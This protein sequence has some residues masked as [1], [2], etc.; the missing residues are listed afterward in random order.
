MKTR[1]HIDRIFESPHYFGGEFTGGKRRLP[2]FTTSDK[3]GANWYAHERSDAGKIYQGEIKAEHPFEIGDEKSITTGLLPLLDKLGIKYR[4]VPSKTHMGWWLEVP[5]ISNHSPNEGSNPLDV[6]YIPAVR[7]ELIRQGYD[8]VTGW[9]NLETTDI[10]VTILIKDPEHFQVTHEL[11]KVPF[12][13]AV[14]PTALFA[15]TWGGRRN[16]KQSHR[17]TGAG[18]H[19]HPVPAE[20][21]RGI[22]RVVS[23]DVLFKGVESYI[24]F[25]FYGGDPKR[26]IAA[27]APYG[28]DS[29]SHGELE[30][31]ID[32]KQVTWSGEPQEPGLLDYV[33]CEGRAALMADVLELKGYGPR[34]FHRARDYDYIITFWDEL[35][36]VK[37]VLLPAVNLCVKA[38]HERGNGGYT[39]NTSKWFLVAADW[40]GPLDG[41]GDARADHE[42][43]AKMALQRQ[44][45]L[46]RPEVKRAMG[47][48]PQYTKA[49]PDLA[50]RQQSF[51]SEAVKAVIGAPELEEMRHPGDRL[52]FE[53]HCWESPES[54]DAQLWYRSHQK[55]TLLNLADCEGANMPSAKERREEACPLVY[56]VKFDDGFVGDAMEDE[57]MDS[58]KQFNRPNPPKMPLGDLGRS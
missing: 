41:A 6:V 16:G 34:K 48:K 52:W 15:R 47:I 23:P 45:H 57:L 55:V 5:E 11:D 27:M 1:Q 24:T 50:T 33:E 32:M 43:A 37:N 42:Q 9:D 4:Y 20:N 3:S 38:S 19:I 7:E 12:G 28:G 49:G 8:S 53:Y 39:A 18:C 22:K 26:G 30:G 58:R 25:G 56:R 14:A 10:P 31:L 51:T 40:A 35:E 17:A 2:I 36:T 29:I 46:A 13:E 21:V 44:V 54:S